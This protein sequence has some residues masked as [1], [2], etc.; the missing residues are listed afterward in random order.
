MPL[1]MM[2]EVHNCQE[3]KKM[4]LNLITDNNPFKQVEGLCLD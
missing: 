3:K 1:N 4:R 2:Q